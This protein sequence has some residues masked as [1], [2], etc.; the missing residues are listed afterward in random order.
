M[1][2]Y[3]L[4]VMQSLYTLV[5]IQEYYEPACKRALDGSYAFDSEYLV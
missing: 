5:Y 4:V 1:L 2:P 3:K